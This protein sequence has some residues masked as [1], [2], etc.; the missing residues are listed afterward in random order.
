MA[1][2]GHLPL[3]RAE[4]RTSVYIRLLKDNALV[5]LLLK[6]NQLEAGKYLKVI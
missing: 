6:A 3:T 4:K 2:T 5:A 1:G